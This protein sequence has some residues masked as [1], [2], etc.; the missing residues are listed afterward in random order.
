MKFTRRN[1]DP[2]FIRTDR[3]IK[4]INRP[5]KSLPDIDK[6]FCQNIQPDIEFFPHL[7]DCMGMLCNP[8]LTPAV[9][10][11]TQKGDQG[12]GGRQNHSLGNA[13]LYELGILFQGG[14]KEILTWQK[15]NDKLRGRLK[16]L[17]VSLAA[18]LGEMRTDQSGVIFQFCHPHPIIIRLKRLKIR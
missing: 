9:R 8:F 11:G 2:T 3:L 7:S 14:G 16:L 1:Q 4:R 13:E 15:Q 5:V 18:Q 17:P 10:D 6:M 12:R